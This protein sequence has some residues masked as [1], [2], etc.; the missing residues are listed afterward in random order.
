MRKELKYGG[1]SASPSDHETLEG[2]LAVAMNLIPEHNTIRPVLPP[3]VIAAIPGDP[4]YPNDIGRA[5]LCIHETSAF[6][7]FIVSIE[8]EGLYHVKYYSLYW[9]GGEESDQL[10]RIGGNITFSEIHSVEPVGNTLVV[11]ADDG[12][13]YILWSVDSNDYRYMGQKPPRIDITFGLSSELVACPGW[14]DDGTPAAPAKVYQSWNGESGYMPIPVSKLN[15]YSVSNAGSDKEPLWFYPKQVLDGITSEK[16]AY[17]WGGDDF[18][19]KDSS[20]EFTKN[21]ISNFTEK[22]MAAVNKLIVEEGENKGRFIMPFFVR[23]AYRLYDDTVVMHSYPVLMIPNSRG[24]FFGLNHGNSV[25]TQTAPYPGTVVHVKKSGDNIYIMD[26]TFCGRAYAFA[27][28]LCY[29]ATFNDLED[30]KDII[31]SVDVYVSAPVFTVNQAEKVYGWNNMDDPGKWDSFYTIGRMADGTK[32]PGASA[33]VFKK[34]TMEDV[35]P[36]DTKK[37]VNGQVKSLF[38][39][40]NYSG[41]AGND[42]YQMPSYVMAVPEFTREEL[43]QRLTDVANF[44]RIHSFNMD[45]LAGDHSSIPLSGIIDIK[46]GALKT[47]LARDRMQDDYFTRD[48]I[49]A[50]H[51]FAYNGRI[52]LSGISRQQHKPLDAHIAWTK[53]YTGGTR[54]YNVA[55]KIPNQERT[56]LLTSGPGQNDTDKPLF[57]FYPDPNAKTALIECAGSVRELKLKEHPFLWGA[58]WLADIWGNDDDWSNQTPVAGNLPAE[59]AQPVNEPNK[60]YTSKVN[61]PFFFPATSINTVGTGEIMGTCAAVKPVSTGQVGYANLYIFADNGVWVAKINQ[62]GAYTNIDLVAGDVCINPG[63]ITQT[64]TSVLFATKRGIMLISGSTTQCISG[65]IDDDGSPFNA[66]EL[67][68]NMETIA[69]LLDMDLDIAP[70]KVYLPLCRMIYDYAGQRIIAYNPLRNYAYIYSFESNKWGMMQSNINYSIRAYPD[71]LAVNHNGEL[72]N[73]SVGDGSA[74]V[75]QLLLTRPLTLDYPDVLKTIRVVLQRG[76][77]RMRQRKV[78]SLLYGSRDLYNWHLV[79]SSKDEN[80]RGRSGTPYKWFRVALIL[81]LPESESIEGCS[82]E[83]ENK[84]T[85][86]LR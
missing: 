48:T 40:Y 9:W 59:D 33:T 3:K 65:T 2:D 82:I 31:H 86:R 62:E 32:V 16:S 45:E 20:D 56:N 50:K 77:F 28:K 54:R 27:S 18:S 25:D 38:E 17:L 15:R 70:F 22:I 42:P 85:N 26:Y 12:V 29:E 44:Y 14:K 13:H 53:Y 10:H 8:Y 46:D 1:Y 78:Q 51:G 36:C 23:Y 72:I 76:L 81:H 67:H 57:V 34:W 37:T 11:L 63:S 41:T 30:W 24:P 43:M 35:F 84:Y 68:D 64:E 66:L 7:H 6:K 55:F 4:Y 71:A 47:L 58:Y 60:V 73:C 49:V 21:E 52:N 5:I 80:M 79:M 39:G 19:Y 83:F 61:N 75:N 74:V 69:G